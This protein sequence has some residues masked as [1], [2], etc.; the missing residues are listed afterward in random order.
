MRH[1]VHVSSGQE[2]KR[3]H[4]L[5]FITDCEFFQIRK[6]AELSES[7]MEMKKLKILDN[8]SAENMDQQQEFS[9]DIMSQ[10]NC[11]T[12]RQVIQ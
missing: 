10:H 7:A 6:A 4:Y 2:G 11:K 5:Q 3:M 1:C 9:E 8:S 12:C